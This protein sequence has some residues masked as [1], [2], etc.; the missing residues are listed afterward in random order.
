[1]LKRIVD[2]LDGTMALDYAVSRP[3]PFVKATLFNL[4]KAKDQRVLAISCT[5]LGTDGN[6]VLKDHRLP[7]CEAWIGGHKDRHFASGGQRSLF[8]VLRL[9]WNCLPDR[10]APAYTR[11]SGLRARSGVINARTLSEGSYSI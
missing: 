10:Q 2:V 8:G 11:Q 6:G 7:R 1:M 4:W 5:S 3:A 9:S